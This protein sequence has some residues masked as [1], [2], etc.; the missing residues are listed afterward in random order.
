MLTVMNSKPTVEITTSFQRQVW[1]EQVFE[2]W[3]RVSQVSPGLV[4]HLIQALFQYSKIARVI[5][6]Q[7]TYKQQPV[8]A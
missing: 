1:F 3:V 8:S 4:A 2:G 5:P 6:S 7:G